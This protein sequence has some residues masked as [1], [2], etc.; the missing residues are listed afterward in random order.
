MDKLTESQAVLDR[1][2]P[3]PTDWKHGQAKMRII[4]KALREL[5]PGL[6]VFLECAHDI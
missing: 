4:E 5:V 6:S 3:C 2:Y 1:L